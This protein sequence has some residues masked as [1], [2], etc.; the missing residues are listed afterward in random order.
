MATAAL[1]LLLSAVSQGQAQEPDTL[2]RLA[3]A[4]APA[5]NAASI[6]PAPNR[7]TAARAPSGIALDG[8]LDEPMWR[9][10]IPVTG[11]TQKDPNEGQPATQRTE[12]RVLYD[13]GALYIGAE[14][15]RM[16]VGEIVAQLARRDRF[17]TA[18]RFFVFLDPYKDG[19][20]GFYFGVNAAGT[21]YDGTLYNDD[22]DSDTWDGIWDAK[23][24]RTGRGWT[25]EIGPSEQ[26][27]RA[28]MERIF[29]S[30]V[31]GRLWNDKIFEL[32]WTP[33]GGQWADTGTFF[34]ESAEFFDPVQGQQWFGKAPPDLSLAARA[35]ASG[36]DWVYTYLKSFYVDET[37]PIGW[38]NTLFP[39]VSMPNPLWELQ[40]LQH[41]EFGEPDATGER[42]VTGLKVT[43]PGSLD[44][45]AFDQSVRDITAFLEYAGE[46]AALKRQ[47][48]GV[49]VILFLAA[50]TFLAWLLK[51][52]YWRDVH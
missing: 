7:V 28:Q 27:R 2:R 13:E 41:A 6:A 35:R 38:N 45:Q 48:M 22:W 9:T 46:P 42:P 37:R 12:V 43:Q 4:P 51:K 21:L 23:V 32:G 36:P 14:L 47:S 18:D 5:R 15:F 49:W 39:G 44:P 30:S 1:L 19:R 11:F 16:T 3:A 34:K 10:A 24:E 17:I 25:V 33:P 26:A 29:D 31:V 52:E 20:T 8:L 50:F 40:G